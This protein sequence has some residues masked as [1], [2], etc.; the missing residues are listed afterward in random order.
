MFSNITPTNVLSM[1][2]FIGEFL[3]LPYHTHILHF[4]IATNQNLKK[5]NIMVL[6]LINI[7][8]IWSITSLITL[9]PGNRILYHK[10]NNT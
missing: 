2:C 1:N 9:S 6:V 8:D 4:H 7:F 3:A 10:N 5:V